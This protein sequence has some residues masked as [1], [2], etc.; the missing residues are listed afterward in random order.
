MATIEQNKEKSLNLLKSV[1]REGMENLIQWLEESDYFTAPA[2]KSHHSNFEGGLVSHSLKVYKV[3]KDNC[4][5][6]NT[7]INLSEESIIIISL[8]HDLCKVNFYH[9]VMKFAKNDEIANQ[10]VKIP[11]YEIKEDFP[12]GHGEKSVDIIRDFIKLSEEE[13][14]CIRW[15][16]GPYEG[17][18]KWNEFGS[19]CDKYPSVYL[20]HTSD[21]ISSKLYEKEIDRDYLI[22]KALGIN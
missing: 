15:H 2:A 16:M 10:W 8:L 20:F 21:V 13:K 1:K 12:Y 17:E 9:K 22:R 7:K 19:A 6:H 5:R 11:Q 3:F 18:N 14:L 4:E